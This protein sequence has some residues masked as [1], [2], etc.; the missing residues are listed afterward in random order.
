MGYLLFFVV[1][2]GFCLLIPRIPFLAKSGLA[3]EYLIVF[4][5]LR[6]TMG[7][8]NCYLS[9]HY[10]A[11]S[12]SL[13]FHNISLN[14]Y[15]LF[16]TDPAYFFSETFSNYNNHYSGLLETSQSFWNNLKTNV[17]VKPLAILNVLTQRNFYL[18]TL[19]F[20]IPV[21]LGTVALYRTLKIH[22]QHYH[23]ILAISVFLFPSA[24]FY[25]SSI[26]RDGLV[27][28]CLGFLIYVLNQFFSTGY[29]VKRLLLFAF[30]FLL[31]FSLRN[32]IAFILVPAIVAWWLSWKKE[33]YS[34]F[35]FSLVFMLCI[36]LF[37]FMRNVIPLADFPQYV[38]NRQ[39]DFNRIAEKSRTYL[40]TSP[41]NPD[42]Y[43]FLKSFPLA[44]KHAFLL[45][46]PGNIRSI[47][48]A[49]FAL[50]LLLTEILLCIWLIQRKK[51]L[52]APM[53]CFILFICFFNILM[54][55]YTVPNLGAIV[56]YRSI[57]LNMVFIC[58]A[59]SINW[60]NFR[61]IHIRL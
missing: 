20:N 50:E 13:A 40:P 15:Y 4:F 55:G 9:Y 33:K 57:Y 56:R 26:H 61:I 11:V 36:L 6:A 8:I 43:S 18:N 46:H 10:F 7:V 47:M 41:L 54:I 14:E 5:M 53:I 17:I 49:P 42:F 19:I 3:P 39:A 58:L 27:W 2:V 12:D 59:C 48:Q 1:L 31:I 22:F 25:T 45:P 24:L 32:Y 35:I 29:N 44:F 52:A 38:I 51:L 30:S 60:K 16:T 21:F 28:M 37:F 23:F 34:L